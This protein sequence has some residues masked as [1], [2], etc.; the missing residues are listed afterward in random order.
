MTRTMT[1][2]ARPR[3]AAPVLAAPSG[4]AP[5]LDPRIEDA[6]LG[7]PRRAARAAVLRAHGAT[8]AEAA[9]LLAYGDGDACT[10]PSPPPFPLAD[11]PFAAAWDEYVAAADR[12]GAWPVLRE[13]LV[14]LRFPVRAGMSE[15][16][17]YRRATRAGDLSGVPERGVTLENAAG[18][19]IWMHATPAGRVPVILAGT[20]ADFE[21]LV[22]AITARNEPKP[23][24]G[25]MG[26]CIVAGY[27]NWD[28]VARH[29]R[30][31]AAAHPSGDWGEEFR[32]LVPRRELYQDRF[33]I[34]S[35]G[36]YS[37]V[38]ASAAGRTEQ[39]WARESVALRL[40]HECAHY[41][42]RRVLGSMRNT[43]R[44][45]LVADFAGIRA[46]A[47]RFRADWLLGFLG[48]ESF[49]AY[50]PGGRLENYRGTLSDGAFIVLQRLAH[51]A[52]VQL[53]AFAAALPHAADDDARAAVL[54]TLC[55]HSLEEI[56]SGALAGAA[57]C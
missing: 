22:R 43:L 48:L 31:W 35:P 41:F 4:A 53:A 36:P 30:A 54:L 10:L 14:Q 52:A 20:R 57:G 15:S 56:A 49:P 37:G 18:L 3:P 1:T 25:S 5:S 26:A 6:R 13:V 42:T 24:P 17:E 19:R 29:R 27:P 8:D 23:L 47:G 2:L 11:E 34:L 16:P 28:R 21:T 12:G 46:A 38:P 44:D 7:D 55:A 50:R 45:E 40:E 51:A 32:A 9:E 39:E 33:I